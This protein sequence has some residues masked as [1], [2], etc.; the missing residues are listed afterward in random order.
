MNGAEEYTSRMM[1]ELAPVS[2]R[3]LSRYYS[4]LTMKIADHNY[5]ITNK[6]ISD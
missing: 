2:D 6:L 1:L 5:L 3:A 4:W